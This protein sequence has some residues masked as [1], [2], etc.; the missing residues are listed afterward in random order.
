MKDH[1]LT[2]II[3]NQIS[4][5]IGGYSTEL[6]SQMS[7]AL[8]YYYGEPF[9]NEIEGRSQFVTREVLEVIE[10]IKGELLKVFASGDRYVVFDGK[11]TDDEEQAKQETDYINHIFTKDNEGFQIVYDI[12]HD[13]CLQKLAYVKVYVDDIDDNK[14]VTYT[15]L[16]EY[17]LTQVLEGDEGKEVEPIE[18]DMQ[19]NGFEPFYDVKVRETTTT[20][21]VC[22]EVIPQEQIIV[23][24]DTSSINLDKASFVAHEKPTTV[25]ELVEAGIDRELAISLP[26][27]DDYSRELPLARE[28]TEGEDATDH[29]A[30]D[31]SMIEKIVQECYM[32][33]DTD[34]DGVAEF[35]KIWKS[36][37]EILLNEEID[38]M[39]IVA[40]S[41][42]PQPHKHVGLSV[43]ELVMDLQL[44]KSTLVRQMLDNLYLT[45]NPEKE[46]VEKNVNINDLLTSVPGGIKRVTQP[47]SINA[48]TVPYTAGQSMPMLQI[49]DQMKEDRT[50]Q[51]RHTKGLDAD[52]LNQSTHGAFKDAIQEAQGLTEKI[53]RTLAEGGFSQLFKKIHALSTKNQDK[54]RVVK[55]R[56]KFVEV[57]PSLWDER[58]DVTVNVGLGTGSK[59]KQLKLIGSVIADQKEHMMQGSPLVQ[60]KHIYNSYNKLIELSEL[61]DVSLYYADPSDPQNQPKPTPPQPNPLAEAEMVKA[62]AAKEMEQLKAQIK[63]AEKKA[64]IQGKIIVAKMNNESSEKIAILNAE[65]EA[66]TTGFNTDIGLPG[67]GAELGY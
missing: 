65:M 50:G 3:D 19:F 12:I 1:E 55:L 51:S 41:P 66:L 67:I 59:D 32:M 52:V 56:D 46:V 6:E 9:G 58:K 21:K 4:S 48:L 14:T 18:A 42:I 54:P 27:F 40:F 26:N 7:D 35:R 2:T 22:V 49:L 57:N 31:D 11:N 34:D 44:L 37:N 53:A 39:P 5:S 45:N 33:I 17:Q 20:K 38:E 63:M 13:C 60:P 64:D 25:S 24:K 23:G 8:D 29:S 47:G 36:G 15:G 30:T 28:Q 10:W 62:Q 61:K 43:A 16:S